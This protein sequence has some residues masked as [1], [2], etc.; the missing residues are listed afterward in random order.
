[1]HKRTSRSALSCRIFASPAKAN[2]DL[3]VAIGKPREWL[4][5]LQPDFIRPELSEMGPNEGQG[6]RMQGNAMTPVDF[7]YIQYQLGSGSWATIN[8]T[9]ND[10]QYISHAMRQAQAMLPGRRI[11]AIDKTGRLVDL[12]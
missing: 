8:S 10:P 7:V 11:R 6:R 3:R 1:M 5:R 12:L 2:L 9:R 4:E